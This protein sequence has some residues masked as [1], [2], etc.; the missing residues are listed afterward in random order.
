MRVRIIYSSNTR[1]TI[2]KHTHTKLLVETLK[3]YY[4]NII[5]NKRKVIPKNRRKTKQNQENI[6]SLNSPRPERI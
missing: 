2:Y 5:Q 3:L 6:N 1:N 4:Q